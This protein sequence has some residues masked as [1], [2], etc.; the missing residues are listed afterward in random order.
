MGET[1]SPQ[2]DRGPVGR[3]GWLGWWGRGLT[4]GSTPTL[5]AQLELC[6]TSEERALSAGR[7]PLPAQPHEGLSAPAR[8]VVSLGPPGLACGAARLT[9]PP[10]PGRT[11]LWGPRL[12]RGRGPWQA[13]ARL[14]PQRPRGEQPALRRG[15]AGSTG[16]PRLPGLTMP[17]GTVPRPP[18]AAGPDPQVRPGLRRPG[19]PHTQV[20]AHPGAHGPPQSR[21]GRIFVV[22]G[23]GAG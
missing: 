22:C 2:P 7:S 20:L 9:H 19:P 21:A 13:E 6:A 12:G 16:R 18:A 8:L 1:G 17:V 3:D 4:P 10:P 5:S 15:L 23:C 14:R 11:G